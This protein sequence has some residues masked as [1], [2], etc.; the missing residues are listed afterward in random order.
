MRGLEPPHLTAPAPK[1]SVSTNSTTSAQRIKILIFG[2]TALPTFRDP[3]ATSLQTSLQELAPLLTTTGSSHL[4]LACLPI[5]PLALKVP[6]YFTRFY[7][8]KLEWR[9]RNSFLIFFHTFLEVAGELLG[10]VNKR[11]C[12]Q[13][14]LILAVYLT[15]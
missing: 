4:K 3:V 5:P 7:D 11:G 15:S 9:R 8:K 6:T 12:R 14:L 13:V 2:T 1:T 10:G